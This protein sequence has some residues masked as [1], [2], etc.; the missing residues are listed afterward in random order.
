MEALLQ[1]KVLLLENIHPA[2]KE[3][4]AKLG[5]SVQA[6]TTSFNEEELLRVLPDFHV[7][8][9][10]SKTQLTE[11]VLRAAVKLESIGCY[12]I[13][14]NQV[15]LTAATE[16]GTAVFNAPYSNTRSVAELVIAEIIGLSR[17]LAE[18]SAKMHIGEWNKSAKGSREVRGKSLGI[19]GYGHI[20]SQVS[21]LAEAMG[22][23]VYFYDV[24][25]K[26]PLGNAKSV[27]SLEELL[28]KADFVT[29]HVPET[30][31]T[32]NLISK[33]EISQMKDGA[34]LINASRGTVVVIPDLAAALK[35][36]KL[37][38]AALDVFPVEPKDNTEKFVSPLQGLGNV[39]LTPHVGGSTEEAQEAIGH[40]VTNSLLG[41]MSEGKSYG[42]VQ[43]PVIDVPPLKRGI[44]RLLNVH[45]NVP[46]VLGEVNSIV[47]KYGVNIQ[48]QYLA[49]NN[50]IGYLVMDLETTAALAD[51]VLGAVAGLKTSLRNRLVTL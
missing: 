1:K 41:Y 9:I 28:G 37:A 40:E 18:M 34:Y 2:A 48:A 25:K 23:E 30:P 33:N 36:K 6:E 29:V 26:L 22:L 11:K 38:G 5:Y 20:G 31:E 44:T 7:I 17:N 10:R 39:I 21:V 8:G 12:C 13:G 14:T 15:A 4:F 45:R 35:E 32:F 24:V 19:V 27:N 47:S 46:G 3:N 51:S 50:A 43:F 49:T 42:A 16:M